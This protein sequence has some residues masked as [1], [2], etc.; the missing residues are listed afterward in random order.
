MRNYL[1]NKKVRKN[2]AFSNM[3][4]EEIIKNESDTRLFIEKHVLPILKKQT[5]LLLNGTLGS[6]KTF[7]TNILVNLILESENRPQENVTSPTFNIVKIYNTKNFDIYHFD[8]YRIK[9]V[10]E[11]Y[12]LDINDAF[13]NISI[14][15]WSEIIESILPYK[16]IRLNIKIKNEQRVYKLEY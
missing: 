2:L 9:N 3:V 4:I 14:I 5:I 12:E 15:E 13:E 16:P 8:L 6:G 11:L 1:N 7:F 10:E